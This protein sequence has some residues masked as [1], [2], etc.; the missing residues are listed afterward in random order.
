MDFS[1]APATLFSPA[2]LVYIGYVVL[3]ALNRIEV[4]V[5]QFLVASVVFLAVQIWH[6]D[7]YRIILNQKAEAKKK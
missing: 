4:S 2:K 3:A 7:Y 6:D 1:S 5:F